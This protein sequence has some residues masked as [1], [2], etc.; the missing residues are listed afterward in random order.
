MASNFSEVDDAGLVFELSK[1][2]HALV[3]ARFQLSM[4]RLDDTSTVSGLRKNIARIQTELRRREM[5][6]G[7]P[8]S[9]LERR[10]AVDAASVRGGGEEVSS[11]GF[12]K[13]V[14]DRIAD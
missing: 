12:L 2:R 3:T 14:V 13:G 1:A 11:G 8:K 7:L 4:N 5:G 9:T 10:H 6:A